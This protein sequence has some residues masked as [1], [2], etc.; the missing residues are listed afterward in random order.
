MV[1]LRCSRSNRR[2]RG[3]FLRGRSRRWWR[4]FTCCCVCAR[5]RFCFQA[6]GGIRVDLVTGVQTCALPISAGR[7]VVQ[8]QGFFRFTLVPAR[9]FPYGGEWK[10]LIATMEET[11]LLHDHPPGSLVKLDRYLH[12]RDRKSVV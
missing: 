11:L 12:N 1:W 10:G 2:R 4:C 9:P 8:E 3:I 5:G 7:M 6:E